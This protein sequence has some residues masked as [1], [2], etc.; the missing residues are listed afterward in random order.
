MSREYQP[1]QNW[2]LQQDGATSFGRACSILVGN[3]ILSLD[4]VT[5][6]MTQSRCVDQILNGCSVYALS[7]PCSIAA[8][9]L[10][11]MGMSKQPLFALF[12]TPYL[13][14]SIAEWIAKTELDIAFLLNMNIM[15][16]RQIISIDELTDLYY[17]YHVYY[18]SNVI[19]FEQYL[20]RLEK[21]TND[22][23]K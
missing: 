23:E 8:V 10:D 20:P 18:D 7:S 19:L 21:G 9:L 4:A 1:Y 13:M 15:Q 16:I 3:N 12:H 5:E 11:E 6:H 2:M 14:N 17:F 22:Y